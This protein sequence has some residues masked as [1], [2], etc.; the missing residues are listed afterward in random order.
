MKLVVRRSGMLGKTIYVL[1]IGAELSG[2]KRGWIDKYKFG[3][4]LLYSRK[5]RPNAD[6]NSWRAS[7]R[8]SSATPWT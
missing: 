6:P 7:V 2:E 5:I 4:S 3:N 8:S 1:D